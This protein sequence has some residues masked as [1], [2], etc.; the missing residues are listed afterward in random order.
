MIDPVEPLLN[1]KYQ[2]IWLYLWK[3]RAKTSLKGRFWPY[4]VFCKKNLA[5]EPRLSYLSS[6][7]FL[8][9]W[10]IARK[11]RKICIQNHILKFNSFFIIENK[12]ETFVFRG[13]EKI[14]WQLFCELFDNFSKFIWPYFADSWTV[15]ELYY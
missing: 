2:M 13:I 11:P 8:R 7:I 5:I 10:Y 14:N 12:S 6:T 9:K 15:V 3:M 4:T 1:P